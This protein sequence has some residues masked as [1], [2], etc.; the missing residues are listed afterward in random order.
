MHE[1]PVIAIGVLD[2]NI[3]DRALVQVPELYAYGRAGKLFG[4]V[5]FLTYMMDGTYQV[6]TLPWM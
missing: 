4:L 5:R 6:S 2:R 3:S 1:V